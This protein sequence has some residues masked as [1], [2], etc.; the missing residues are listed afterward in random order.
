MRNILMAALVSVGCVACTEPMSELDA[1]I[2]RVKQA[3]PPPIEPLPPMRNFKTH[4]Y[5]PT[6]DPFLPGTGEDNA[7]DL[8]D[9]QEEDPLKPDLER[10]RELLEAFPI[11][12]L[13]MVGTMGEGEAIEALVKDPDGVVHRVRLGNW[14]GQNFGQVV[15]INEDSIELEERVQDPIGKWERRETAIALDDIK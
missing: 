3:P 13:D 1:Y 4:T 2:T 11:D 12:S 5:V 7:V 14:L 9:A 6:R 10:P 15:A 8:A